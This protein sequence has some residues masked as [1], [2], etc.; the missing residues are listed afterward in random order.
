MPQPED[1]DK[2]EMN[3]AWCAQQHKMVKW[4]MSHQ[5]VKHGLIA[6]SP[7]FHIAPLVS[8]WAIES[9]AHPGAVGWWVLAGDLPID[10]FSA[11][12]LD[13][14]RKVL[15][16]AADKWDEMLENIEAG[17]PN[18]V[19]IPGLDE[20]PELREMLAARSTSLRQMAK[21]ERVWA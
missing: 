2:P 21:D 4:F 20:K 18:K 9:A 8:V 10:Y 1:F 12:T 17:R 15:V 6:S 14:P 3:D 19:I 5:S 16:A 11:Q 7:A 13:H